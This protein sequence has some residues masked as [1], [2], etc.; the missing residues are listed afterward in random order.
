[1]ALCLASRILGYISVI[2]NAV[3]DQSLVSP[4]GSQ[5]AYIILVILY[6]T[7][8]ISSFESSSVFQMRNQNLKEVKRLIYVHTNKANQ[9]FLV[10]SLVLD[11]FRE[12]NSKFREESCVTHFITLL[13]VE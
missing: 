5:L 3:S 12:I 4:V 2:F 6:R 11:L 10:K 8:H 9:G 13:P 7:P 1:M